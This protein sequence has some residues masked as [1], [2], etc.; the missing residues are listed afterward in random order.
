MG[1]VEVEEAEENAASKSRIEREYRETNV[2][3]MHTFAWNVN[4]VRM[5]TFVIFFTQVTS[6]V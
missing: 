6:V 2:L 5:N 1:E 4:W 3:L